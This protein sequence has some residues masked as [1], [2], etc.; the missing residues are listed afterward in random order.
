MFIGIDLG[1][2]NIAG[3]LVD[4]SGQ[5]VRSISKPTL[6]ERGSDAIIADIAEIIQTLRTHSEDVESVGIGIPGIA[7]PHTGVVL[8]CVNLNWYDVPLREKLETIVGIPVFIDNDATVA[9]VAEF[10]VAQKG[11]YT[12]AVILTLGT[13]VGGGLLVNG[14]VVSGHHGIGSEMGHMI[15]GENFYDCNCGRNG[16]L[17]TFTSSKAII[18]YTKHLLENGEVSDLIMTAAHGDINNINGQIIFD[19]AKKGDALANKV[20]DRLVKYLS[21]G[22]INIICVV[23]PEIILLGGGISNA[24]DFLVDKI[25][26]ALEDLKYYKNSALAKIEIAKLK[27]DAGII[28]AAIY[29]KMH[30]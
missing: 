15:I 18:K 22:I 25:K 2:T 30:Q 20:V 19:A 12:N 14:E 23:D 4:A 27:N 28:G 3:G 7:D 11:Q 17:E 9:G 26:L 5:I 29:A 21:R 10:Q 13:G 1:G 24:G 8:A 16:C 6:V